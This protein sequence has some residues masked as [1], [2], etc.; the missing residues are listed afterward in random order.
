MSD[1][2]TKNDEEL[3][4][5]CLK[6]DRSSQEALYKKYAR[7]M[8]G[9]CLSYANDSD[10]A[11]DMLQDGFVKIFK[12]IKSYDGQ[13]SFEGWIRRIV[14]NT[15]IDYFRRERRLNNYIEYSDSKYVTESSSIYQKLNFEEILKYIR[16][17]PDGARVIFDLFAVEGY[18]HK[19]IAMKLNISE[20]TSK[21]QYNR[22]RSL[23]QKMILKSEE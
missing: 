19:E 15:A 8:Y 23:L 17:L 10:S 2:L 1:Y 7:T 6:G 13:G 14:T 22:A 3:L 4:K 21:S 5:G 16:K 20:G 18:S 12:K 11:Q 9:I